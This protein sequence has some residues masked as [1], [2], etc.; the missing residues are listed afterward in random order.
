M[1]KTVGKP[2]ALQGTLTLRDGFGA[3]A[4]F[5]VSVRDYELRLFRGEHEVMNPAPA[6]EPRST[7]RLFEPNGG[8]VHA[9][10]HFTCVICDEKR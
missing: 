7:L 10:G 9:T 6:S 5:E 4:S 2:E 8:K 3:T 1:T